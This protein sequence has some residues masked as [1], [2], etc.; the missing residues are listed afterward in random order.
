MLMLTINAIA[1][2]SAYRRTRLH[3]LGKLQAHLKFLRNFVSSSF[4]LS[5][6]SQNF[7]S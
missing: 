7:G 6:R 5:F 1:K 3:R 2:P 4:F